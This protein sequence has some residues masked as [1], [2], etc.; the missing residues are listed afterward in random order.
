MPNASEAGNNSHA[1]AAKETWEPPRLTYLGHIN[2]IVQGGGGKLS[3][4]AG[5]PGDSRK[6]PSLDKP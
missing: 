6:V 3:P 2:E 4:T 5:D 1:V